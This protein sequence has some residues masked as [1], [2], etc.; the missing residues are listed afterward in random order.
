MEERFLNQ[1]VFASLIVTQKI[2][3][4]QSTLVY[5]KSQVTYAQQAQVCTKHGK[6]TVHLVKSSPMENCQ[7]H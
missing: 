5:N 4:I 6:R 3:Y 7:L 2:L 1:S